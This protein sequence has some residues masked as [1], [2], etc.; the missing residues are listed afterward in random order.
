MRMRE[1]ATDQLSST[2]SLLAIDTLNTAIV[3]LCKPACMTLY[4]SSL[5]RCSKQNNCHNNSL[6]A[7][8]SSL[9]DAVLFCSVILIV[10]RLNYL[11]ICPFIAGYSLT[12]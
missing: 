12:F 2:G 6:H 10:M 8:S 5:H 1:H 3:P 7:A 11:I 4:N 9:S